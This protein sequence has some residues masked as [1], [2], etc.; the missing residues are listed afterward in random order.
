MIYLCLL[1]WHFHGSANFF[2]LAFLFDIKC[3][4]VEKWERSWVE[5]L[6]VF[7]FTRWFILVLYFGL[8][9]VF[10]LVWRSQ[11]KCL[12]F[13]GCLQKERCSRALCQ[14]AVTSC[15]RGMLR[16]ALQRCLLW[17][18]RVG[19]FFEYTLDLV[20]LL[21]L[22]SLVLSEA[23][24]AQTFY[25]CLPHGEVIMNFALLQVKCNYMNLPYLACEQHVN[26]GILTHLT[27]MAQHTNRKI[28]KFA[29]HCG[30]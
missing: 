2:L 28:S 24:L 26:L 27:P 29:L 14:F 23:F 20:L 15:A 25:W 4:Q 8:F 13:S 21:L 18:P 9:F 5:T 12:V 7:F 3:T 1:V 6:F 11:N 30:F 16:N 10:F 22:C 17:L 19:S